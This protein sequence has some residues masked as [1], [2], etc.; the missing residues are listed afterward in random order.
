M[1]VVLMKLEVQ[2]E[3]FGCPGLVVVECSNVR[4]ILFYSN[5]HKNEEAIS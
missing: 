1:K 4:N 3:T 5:G 2:I